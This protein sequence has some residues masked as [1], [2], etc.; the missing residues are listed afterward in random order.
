MSKSKNQKYKILLSS[1]KSEVESAFVLNQDKKLVP[2]RLDKF[3][4]V[5]FVK[6]KCVTKRDG[7]QLYDIGSVV[8]LPEYLKKSCNNDA[9]AYKHIDRTNTHIQIEIT[10]A[11]SGKIKRSQISEGIA[12]KSSFKTNS[13]S[14]V[15]LLFPSRWFD[16]F[17]AVNP[18]VAIGRQKPKMGFGKDFDFGMRHREQI[19]KNQ[20]YQQDA[21]LFFPPNIQAGTHW[22]TFV[23][24]NLLNEDIYIAS[25]PVQLTIE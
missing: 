19:S 3:G 6:D 23:F 25:E 14:P 10:I 13:A 18:G 5:D 15:D 7:F 8:Q 4:P 20:T 21:F 12:F 1:G 24:M 17:H 22:I 16:H 9:A 2:F 11:N